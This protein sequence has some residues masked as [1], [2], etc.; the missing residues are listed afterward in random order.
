MSPKYKHLPSAFGRDYKDLFKLPTH[1][2]RPQWRS[3]AISKVNR[4]IKENLKS[5][6]SLYSAG[7][8]RKLGCL[9]WNQQLELHIISFSFLLHSGSSLGHMQDSES[10]HARFFFKK[11]LPEQNVC[12]HLR[13]R[14]AGT[15]GFNT[16]LE[17]CHVHCWLSGRASLMSGCAILERGVEAG[18]GGRKR[19]KM[20]VQTAQL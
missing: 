15:C 8:S 2:S 9:W 11:V 10:K 5:R 17:H 13:V 20:G 18:G 19:G 3:N 14:D 12:W 16:V 1:L 4:K 6:V 7:T